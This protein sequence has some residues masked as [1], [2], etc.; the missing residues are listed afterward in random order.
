MT[1]FEIGDMARAVGARL[2]GDPSV[3]VSG[4][5][6]PADAG[7]RDLALAMAPAFLAD[8]RRGKARAAVLA[9]GAD[10][11]SLG[12]ASAM[13]TDQP[14][15]TLALITRLFD[16][17]PDVPEGIHRLAVVAESAEI[18]GSACIG[19][20]A[21]VGEG[22]RLGKNCSI[23]PHAVIGSGVVIGD[24]AVI[25]AG[26]KIGRGVQIG[27]RFIAH[28]NAVVGGDGYSF[29]TAKPGAIDEVR[30]TLGGK[31]TRRQGEY[32]RIHSLG[33]V[34]I[35]DDVEVG[36]C[37]AIDRGTV[38]ST[39]IG[40]GTK[41]DDHA[42]VGHNVRIGKHCLICGHVAI[43]GSAVI[44]DRV[45][46]AGMVGVSDHLEIGDDVVAAGAS[47]IFRTVPPGRS[48]M[49]SPAIDLDMNIKLYKSLR[50]VPRLIDQVRELR[51][52]VSNLSDKG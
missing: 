25:H 22:V 31:V 34:E 17:G 48:V 50:R 29:A 5:A 46:L 6:E 15:F 2:D 14:R 52:R 30:S 38:S 39:I 1:E 37:A 44:G 40:S 49:G 3:I 41:L 51:N 27:E 13:F 18:G 26:V 47:K 12:L 19:P 9:E 8:L 10:R 11:E 20:L 23:G 35:G 45:V 28:Q 4:V 24:G 36:A 32:Y 33:A 21:V 43:A 42:H 7:P 16:P